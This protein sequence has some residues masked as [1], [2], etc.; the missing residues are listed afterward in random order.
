MCSDDLDQEKL[1]TVSQREHQYALTLGP[2]V[3]VVGGRFKI[4][5]YLLHLMLRTYFYMLDTNYV[6]VD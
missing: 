5:Q 6:F 1:G 2:L 3:Q 4:Y